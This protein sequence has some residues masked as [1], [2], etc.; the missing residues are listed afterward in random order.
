MRASRDVAISKL[1]LESAIRLDWGLLHL[2]PL[3]RH[4]VVEFSH[5]PKT[6]NETLVTGGYPRILDREIGRAHV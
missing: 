4:E 2:L 5:H 1:D 3:S 6:L